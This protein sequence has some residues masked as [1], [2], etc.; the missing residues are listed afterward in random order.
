MKK[1]YTAPLATEFS[2]QAA[3]VLA[4]SV[5]DGN[6]IYNYEEYNFFE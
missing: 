1:N 4:S 5:Q 6:L 2:V 3:N